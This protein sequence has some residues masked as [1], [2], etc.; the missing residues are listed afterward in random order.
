MF[1]LYGAF[2]LVGF[3]YLRRFLPET[4]SRSLEEIDQELQE[5]AEVAS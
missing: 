5:E 4:K 2:A 1:W 3:F